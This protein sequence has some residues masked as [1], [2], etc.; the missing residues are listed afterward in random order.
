VKELKALKAN[1]F[2]FSV[3]DRKDIWDLKIQVEKFFLPVFLL[4]KYKN[5]I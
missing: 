3:L 1:D 4:I 2:A 5:K